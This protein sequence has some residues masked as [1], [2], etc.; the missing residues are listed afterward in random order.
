MAT[1]WATAISRTG[2]VVVGAALALYV[3]A[4]VVAVASDTP[5]AQNGDCWQSTT[6][7]TCRVTWLGRSTYVYFRAIDQFSSQRSGWTTPAQNAVIAWSTAPGPQ[8]YSFSPHTN[9]T[10]IYMTYSSTGQHGLLSSYTA[11]TWN[12]DQSSYCTDT[13]VAMNIYWSDIYLNHDVLDGRSSAQIQ[14]TF[15]HES[16]HGMGL[17]HNTTDSSSIM[18]PVQTTIGAPDASDWGTYSG[19]SSGGHGT[20]CI[21]GWGD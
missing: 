13:N 10:W 18:W 8:F 21:Y 3:A 4:P 9:D 11:I 2:S 16:G 15:G 12:C 1:S 7:F 6:P 14:N 17:A 19:C 5:S 20:D